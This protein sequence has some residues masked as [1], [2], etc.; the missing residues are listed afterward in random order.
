MISQKS[1]DFLIR[2]LNEIDSLKLILKLLNYDFHLYDHGYNFKIEF[3]NKTKSGYFEL[4]YSVERGKPFL[5]YLINNKNKITEKKIY[6]GKRVP[7]TINNL[8]QLL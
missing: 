8:S 1:E 7:N 5:K 3:H 6:N 2:I 4:N